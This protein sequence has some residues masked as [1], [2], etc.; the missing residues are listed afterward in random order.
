MNLEDVKLNIKHKYEKLEILESFETSK[1]D[2]LKAR[3]DLIEEIAI[4]EVYISRLQDA[5]RTKLQTSLK[6]VMPDDILSNMSRDQLKDIKN[7]SND[8]SLTDDVKDVM[9]HLIAEYQL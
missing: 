2:I 3:K 7:V 5:K 6:E 8:D 9:Y 4:L 1:Y